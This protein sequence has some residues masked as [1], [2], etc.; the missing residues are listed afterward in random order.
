MKSRRQ[1]R[2]YHLWQT[3]VQP[4]LC[5]NSAYSAPNFAETSFKVLLL[6]C[7]NCLRVISICQTLYVNLPDGAHHTLILFT[8]SGG[9]LV[10][11]GGGARLLSVF[12][13]VEDHGLSDEGEFK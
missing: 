11:R 5:V 4:I 9:C 12:G 10:K 13:G 1:F 2:E 8:E 3:T 7:R 6:K